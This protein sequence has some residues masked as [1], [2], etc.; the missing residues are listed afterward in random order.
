MFLPIFGIAP[1]KGSFITIVKK[2]KK[3][4]KCQLKTL[5][6]LKSNLTIYC[7]LWHIWLILI[8]PLERFDNYLR[9]K[10]ELLKIHVQHRFRT[11]EVGSER[12]LDMIWGVGRSRFNL[13][14][15][16]I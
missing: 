14:A 7:G 4:T 9:S 5:L 13:P 11:S 12:V 16:I 15:I 3:K 2:K 6:L 1:T 10:A 8:V